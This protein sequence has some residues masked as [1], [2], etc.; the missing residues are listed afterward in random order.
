MRMRHIVIWPAALYEIFPRYLINCTIFL[1][2]KKV[3]EH[4]MCVFGFLYKL[5][6]KYF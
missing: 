2:K 1:K 3:T 6:L 4:K 5:W